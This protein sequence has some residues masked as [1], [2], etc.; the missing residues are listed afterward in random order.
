MSI[1]IP[2]RFLRQKLLNAS[3]CVDILKSLYYTKIYIEEFFILK[4]HLIWREAMFD[5]DSLFEFFAKKYFFNVKIILF[6]HF[7]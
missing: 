6:E 5:A 3:S 2:K 1:F 7:F 4:L